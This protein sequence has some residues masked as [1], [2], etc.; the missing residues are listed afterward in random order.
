[1]I[2]PEGLAGDRRQPKGS[3]EQTVATLVFGRT[4]WCPYNCI[5]GRDMVILATN[6]IGVLPLE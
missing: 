6:S 2:A 4:V 3:V 1:M 5:H